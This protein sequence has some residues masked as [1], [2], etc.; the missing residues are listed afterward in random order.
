LIQSPPNGTVF[1]SY[2]IRVRP[3]ASVAP[4]YLAHFF[5]SKGYWGQIQQ[6]TQ[7]AAQGGVNATSL[8]EIRVVLPPLDEQRRIAAILDKAD[9]LRRKRKRA[10]EF[11]NALPSSIFLET[12]GDPISNPKGWG[13]AALR[14]LASKIG[15]GATPKGGDAAYKKAG[16]K[17]VRSMN[18][19]DE[20][21]L[22][23]GIAFIV[24]VQAAKLSGVTLE[25]G[26]VLLNITGASVARV[27]VCPEDALPGRVNQHVSI[28]RLKDSCLNQYVA[29]CL[30][31][32]AMKEKLLGIAEAGATRQAI[33]K[34]QIEE[35]K[36][37]MP[38]GA[39]I[40]RF[41]A[42]LHQLSPIAKAMAVAATAEEH[43]FSSLQHRA[44]SG[45]L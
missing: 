35:L 4:A 23:K 2:L 15:S 3:S 33:T 27:C 10:T 9:A 42:T 20:G 17:L 16:I 22:S 21:F 5:Q 19:R 34:A 36:I 32:P 30:K 40:Q 26:D 8:S 28:I 45:Q 12:F 7:G 37:P 25:A 14:S 1:A 6:K 41:N 29:L 13:V 31:M 11:L 24:D 44:F 39:V 18:V 38:S 43:L